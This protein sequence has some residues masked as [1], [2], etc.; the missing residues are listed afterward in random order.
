MF[1]VDGDK[2]LSDGS[3]CDGKDGEVQKKRLAEH[4]KRTLGYIS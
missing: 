1:D 4:F 2:S 3:G